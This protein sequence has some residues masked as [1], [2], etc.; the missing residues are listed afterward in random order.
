MTKIHIAHEVCADAMKRVEILL[1]Q[2]AMHDPNWNGAEFTIERGDF[3]CIP[4]NESYEAA[5]LLS[6]IQA[7]IQGDDQ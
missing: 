5:A 7:A 1:S 6:S 2:V 4:D 3:T